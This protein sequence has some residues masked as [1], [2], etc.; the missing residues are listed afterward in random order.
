MDLHGKLAQQPR[1]L[2][3]TRRWKMT[4]DTRSSYR[5]KYIVSSPLGGCQPVS[6][7]RM[8]WRAVSLCVR[9]PSFFYCTPT[10]GRFLMYAF[11]RRSWQKGFLWEDCKATDNPTCP[12]YCL[13]QARRET[14][15]HIPHF[16][17]IF[18]SSV[19]C[20]CRILVYKYY[21]YISLYLSVARCRLDV[22][23]NGTPNTVYKYDYLYSALHVSVCIL[24]VVLY[25]TSYTE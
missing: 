9:L 5:I 1:W 16:K 17:E 13:N 6:V 25:F 21:L 2:T 12:V 4:D 3:T 20:D 11:T 15:R 8:R 22:T 10:I 23:I 19:K 14:N 18:H 7:K 24:Y